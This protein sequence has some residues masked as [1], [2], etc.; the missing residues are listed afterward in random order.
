MHPLSLSLCAGQIVRPP[1]L[2]TP[3]DI[4]FLGCPG[5]LITLFL[6]CPALYKHSNHSFFQ[7]PAL[8]YHTNVSS[9]PEAAP[10]GMGAEQFDQHII[11]Q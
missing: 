9:D 3:G 8:F 6:P 1:P 4:T 11:N 5:V 2:G 10:R 7:C